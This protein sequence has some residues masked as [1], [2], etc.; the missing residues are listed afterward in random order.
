MNMVFF[1][2]NEDYILRE[3]MAHIHFIHVDI[4][5]IIFY[6]MNYHSSSI[7]PHELLYSPPQPHQITIYLSKTPHH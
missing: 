1:L 6:P 5:V 4:K 3:D 2:I 7:C